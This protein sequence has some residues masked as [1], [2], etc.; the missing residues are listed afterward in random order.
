MDS[1]DFALPFQLERNPVRGRLVRLGPALDRILAAHAYPP[2]VATLLGE[3]VALTALL[4]SAMKYD[5]VFILQAQGDGPI[6]MMVA[7][8]ESGGAIRACA[9]FDAQRLDKPSAAAGP[10]P[11]LLG[12]GTLAFT[13]DQGPDTQRYQGIAELDGAT[14]ADCAHHYFRRSEQLETAI[15]LAAGDGRAGG[16]MLQRMPA[17]SGI[18]AEQAEEDW[19]RAVALAGSVKPVEL[20]D[21]SLAP[22]AL[23]W[24]LF[25]EE[26]VR[27]FEPQ[28]FHAACR[29]SRGRVAATLRSLPRDEVLGLL[30]E[31][32]VTVTCEF[33][34][35][36]QVFDEAELRDLFAGAG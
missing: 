8:I 30:V 36:S 28:A 33:C 25:H 10:V 34:S 32:R 12:A 2:A 21:G 16:L 13:V 29:C 7:D 35:R 19:R 26:D 5:G 24:R 11:R 6:R 22:E 3:T 1:Q 27:V 20:L 4:A 14:L 31:G 18:D 9:R 17:E 23:L 15:L